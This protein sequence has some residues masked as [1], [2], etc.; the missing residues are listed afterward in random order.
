LTPRIVRR[1]AELAALEAEVIAA[2][3]AAALA[4]LSATDGSLDCERWDRAI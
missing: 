3:E 4:T 2:C 1:R